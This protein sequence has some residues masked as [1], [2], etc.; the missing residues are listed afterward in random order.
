MPRDAIPKDMQDMISLASDRTDK[1][2]TDDGQSY[3]SK[4]LSSMQPLGLEPGTDPSLQKKVIKKGKRPKR[5]KHR[6]RSREQTTHSQSITSDPNY[7]PPAPFFEKTRRKGNGKAERRG[8]NCTNSVGSIASVEKASK[9]VDRMTEHAIAG[10]AD[11]IL[12]M[13]ASKAGSGH[14]RAS[15]TS[16]SRMSHTGTRRGKRTEPLRRDSRISVVSS[17]TYVPPILQQEAPSQRG[18]RQLPE[19]MDELF[20]SGSKKHSD[21]KK[22]KSTEERKKK[23]KSKSKSKELRTN[24]YNGPD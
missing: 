4:S 19:S 7:E 3:D 24:S 15:Y 22:K 20:S 9:A 6:T 5:P 2:E 23:K 21:R 14:S 16:H 10:L 11:K 1:V 18:E 13:N 17:N 8:S 12:N